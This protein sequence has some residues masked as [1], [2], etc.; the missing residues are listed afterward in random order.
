MI[1]LYGRAK[2]LD[3][4]F[5]MVQE[6]TTEYKFQP[7]IFVYTCLMQA[8]FHNNQHTRAF[9]LH[10]EIVAA[11]VRLDQKAYIALVRGRLHEYL[12]D[13][14]VDVIRCAFGIPST[15][16]QCIEGHAPGVD[17]HTVT[18]VCSRLRWG[19]DPRL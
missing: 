1:K 4:A 18:E 15:T 5:V 12:F 9:T 13:K 17:V 14:A 16:M 3:E 7:N 10:D 11:G 2:Y 19:R 6:L 8:C